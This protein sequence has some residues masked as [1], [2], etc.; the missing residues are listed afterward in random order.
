MTDLNS[1]VIEGRIKNVSCTQG[2]PPIFTF[3]LNVRRK[4]FK[5]TEYECDSIIP[6]ICIAE[7]EEYIDIVLQ[8]ARARIIGHI[9]EDE[10]HQGD[11]GGPT[12]TVH[13]DG[14]YLLKEGRK[15]EM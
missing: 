4:K 12:L 3:V 2:D 5:G 7:G 8:G 14:L 9:E 1:V 11:F 6:V 13:T 10:I 15:G